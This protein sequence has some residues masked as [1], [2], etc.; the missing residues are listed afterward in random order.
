MPK[1]FRLP[2]LGE[3]VT[4]G[5]VVRVMVA[6][7]ER[8]REDQPLVEVETDK[9][10]VEIP[11]PWSG[12]IAR[13]HV[14]P[15]QVLNVGD[16]MV[17][18]TEV[19]EGASLPAPRAAHVAR[20]AHAAAAHAGPPGA[21]P[22]AGHTPAS[23]AVRK[24]ARE[25]GVNIETIPGSGPGGRVTQ[26]DLERAARRGAPGAPAAA[27]PTTRARP[28]APPPPA[29]P[30][31]GA[32]GTDAWGPTR[33]EPLSRARRTIAEAMVHSAT[34]IPHATDCDDADVTDLDRLRRGYTSDDRPQRKLSL[35]PFAIRATARA[36]RTYAIFNA[37]YDAEKNEVVY[38]DYVAIAIGVHT[39]R[40]LVAPVLRDADTLTIPQIADA[41][42]ALAEK[43]R[44]ASFEVNDTRGG[45][46]TISNA[47]AAG[48]SR[49]STPII[50]P[51]QAAIL[52]L[53]RARQ[54]PWVVD[55]QLVPRLILPLSIS[56][57]HR[58][59]DGADEVRF[60]REIIDLLEN[61]ARLLL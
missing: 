49:Y 54:Q 43:A 24:M 21:A 33:R 36:L 47:G 3:G 37:S 46:F 5:Q 23:P 41:L 18:F 42:A 20:A 14:A 27:A 13:V 30:P 57:D 29:S 59:I 55:G 44:T 1:D 40:G 60:M 22:R 12:V 7:G 16:V 39:G 6:E 48:G 28:A 61:P 45:T 38:H 4:E 10:S 17:T 2:D 31:P 11:S 50:N 52:A 25:L 9:A 15:K 19:A 56:F 53:G 8:V 26:E 58:L 51:P 35:L 32:P 34:T